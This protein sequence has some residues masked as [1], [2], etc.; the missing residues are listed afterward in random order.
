MTVTVLSN[1]RTPTR[2]HFHES[3]REQ[4]DMNAVYR[5]ACSYRATAG[6]GHAPNGQT[7]RLG[8]PTAERRENPVV[9]HN[10]DASRTLVLERVDG[11]RGGSRPSVCSRWC[12]PPTMRDRP[13]ISAGWW[14]R[15]GRVARSIIGEDDLA[16]G[17]RATWWS[18][19][20]LDAMSSPGAGG[21]PE[22]SGSLVELA[23][24]LMARA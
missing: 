12:A 18:N 16:C 6:S 21:G 24:Q 2:G 9:E 15:H 19:C 1:R 5:E 3:L 13:G 17:R 10:Y 23:G 7:C 11:P 20:K 8:G 22:S 4:L 14:R